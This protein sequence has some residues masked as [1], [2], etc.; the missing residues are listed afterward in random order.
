MD[1]IYI[2]TI[3]LRFVQIVLTAHIFWKIQISMSRVHE[4]IIIIGDLSETHRRSIGDQHL[5]SETHWRP[6]C[7]I[8]DKHAWSETNMPHW[9]PIKARHTWSTLSNTSLM[10]YVGL[11]WVPDEASWSTMRPV[12]FR[13][14][15]DQ[16]CQTPMG[17][18]SGILVRHVGLQWVS[19]QTCQSLKDLR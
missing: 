16:A 6:P 13:W 14:V 1:F 15:S 12:G 3:W 8:G 2:F 5:L 11:R 18:W 10:R 4:N 19:Y 17:L 7:L 9:R